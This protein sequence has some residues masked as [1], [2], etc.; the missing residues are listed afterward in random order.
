M[1]RTYALFGLLIGAAALALDPDAPMAQQAKKATVKAGKDEKV[2]RV[3]DAAER[4][5]QNLGVPEERALLRLARDQLREVRHH[6]HGLPV[7][8]AAP[9]S[10]EAARSRPPCGRQRDRE[11]SALPSLRT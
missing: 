4:R 9:G 7:V 8:E 11:P 10:R 6:L 1:K 3:Q 2:C 5:A